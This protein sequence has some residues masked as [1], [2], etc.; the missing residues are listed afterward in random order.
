[1]AVSLETRL[2]YL[3]HRVAEFAWK[4]PFSY[5]LRDGEG[6]WIL[7]KL[8]HNYVPKGLVEGPKMGFSVPIDSWLRGPLR[9]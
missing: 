5:K 7:R 2:P 9:D 8:L 6:K 3:D 1:M 4:L